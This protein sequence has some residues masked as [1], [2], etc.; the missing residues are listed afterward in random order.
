MNKNNKFIN[1]KR[2]SANYS[3]A[4]ID[5]SLAYIQNKP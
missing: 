5:A 3:S 1:F 2:N 4:T